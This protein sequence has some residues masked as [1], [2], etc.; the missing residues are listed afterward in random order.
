MAK[1]LFVADAD[2]VGLVVVAG[3]GAGDDDDA[4][5]V[6]R[7]NGAPGEAADIR[8]CSSASTSTSTSSEQTWPVA[9]DGDRVD[10]VECSD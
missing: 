8:S 10:G 4:D 6:G 2:D 1:A 5:V 7:R 9:Q 3:A